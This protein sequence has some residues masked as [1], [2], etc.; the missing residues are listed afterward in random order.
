LLIKCVNNHGL[1]NKAIYFA[2]HTT[3]EFIT[4]KVSGRTLDG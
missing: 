3:F 1:N 4:D 2:P